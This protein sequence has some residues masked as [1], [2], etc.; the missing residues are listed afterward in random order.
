[1]FE[2]DSSTGTGG[3]SATGEGV[4]PVPQLGVAGHRVRVWVD[5]LGLDSN[6]VTG[7]TVV[8]GPEEF[9]DLSEFTAGGGA[10]ACTCSGRGGGDI[11]LGGINGDASSN[12]KEEHSYRG[13]TCSL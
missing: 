11:T 13:A 8:A 12:K 5:I 10:V 6:S 7:A 3:R 1:M 9:G 2:T 4:R